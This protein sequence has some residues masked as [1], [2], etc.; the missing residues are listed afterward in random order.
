MSKRS[1]VT[2]ATPILLA[3]ALGGCSKDSKEAA[4]KPAP[5]VPGAPAAEVGTVAIDELASLVDTGKCAVLD[6]NN[7]STRKSMGVIPGARLLSDY[8]NYALSELPASKAEKLVFYCANEACGASHA[9][10]AKA[11]LAGYTDVNVFRGGIAGWK[12]A[13]KPVTTMQ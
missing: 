12:Q 13:G 7:D 10:A 11:L 5:P 1:L 6:A 3:L 9:A 2:L 4:A 8:D